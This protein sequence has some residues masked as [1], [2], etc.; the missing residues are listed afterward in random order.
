MLTYRPDQQKLHNDVI[1]AW[2]THRY[3]AAES[4][5]GSGKTVVASKICEAVNK[6][7]LFIAHRQELVLQMSRACAQ[8]GIVHRVEAPEKLIRHIVKC[9]MDEFGQTF[10]SCDSKNVVASIQTLTGKKSRLNVHRWANDI[11]LW[12][13]D[14]GHHLLRDNMWGDGVAM[15]PNALGL[16]M[17]AWFGR[18][19]G[20]GLGAHADGVYE[21]IVRNERTMGDL[22]IDGSLSKFIIYAHECTDIHADKI[23]ISKATGDFQ[24][25]QLVEAVHESQQLTGDIVGKYKEYATGKLGLTFVTDCETGR[26]LAKEFCDKGVSAA[27]IDANTKTTERNN[28]ISRFERREIMNIVNVDIF[29]EG[30]DVPVLE[31]ISMGAHTASYAKY[32]QQFGRP[33]RTAPGKTHA[34]I[35]DHVGNVHRHLLPT[36]LRPSSLNRRDKRAQKKDEDLIPMTTCARCNRVFESLTNI[37]PYCGKEDKSSIRKEKLTPEDVHGDLQLL[38]ISTLDALHAEIANINMDPVDLKAQLNDRYY[39]NH[40]MIN[41][42]LK[43]RR[44]QVEALDNLSDAIAEWSAPNLHAGQPLAERQRRFFHRFGIDVLTVKTLKKQDAI[45]LTDRITK[46]RIG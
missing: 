40:M 23:A 17:S 36:K 43:Y 16:G 44:E 9:H 13:T 15:F 5:T 1:N 12:I 25:K 38:D 34:I 8:N 32:I 21:V 28:V 11:G 18:A 20:K 24:K 31:V 26:K 27:F 14:E 37:C 33:L 46:S 10:Y 4:A 2:R 6:P 35:I 19:D 30:T 45:N 3:V 7:T 41:T 39:G 42:Q 22:I 29:G